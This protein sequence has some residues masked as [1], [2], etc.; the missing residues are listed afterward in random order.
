MTLAEKKRRYWRKNVQL[1]S[2]LTCIWLLVTFGF[3]YFAGSAAHIVW[4]GWPLPFYMAAQGVLIIYVL[5]VWYY[6][7][8]MTALDAQY[9]REPCERDG[10]VNDRQVNDL[11]GQDQRMKDPKVK[12]PKLKDLGVNVQPV[13]AAAP[14]A[15]S[16]ASVTGSR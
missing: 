12:D 5:I 7:H 8:A 3:S 9:E 14:P 15:G 6:A 1:T 2:V 11:K 10:G 16:P 4:F 13:H